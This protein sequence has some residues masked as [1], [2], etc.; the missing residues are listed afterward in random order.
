[1][2]TQAA[3][4]FFA[5]RFEEVLSLT[6]SASFGKNMAA[7]SHLCLL[8]SASRHSLWILGGESDEQLLDLATADIETCSEI[9]PPLLPSPRF[10]SPRFVDFHTASLADLAK[11]AE[12]EAATV[13]AGTVEAETGQ[14]AGAPA[15][16][17][18][19]SEASVETSSKAQG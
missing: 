5:N 9:E 19:P 4:A 3:E 13:S 8:R 14:S 7:R 15:S 12:E 1:M 18:L 10:F 6:E 16:T 17:A 2:L 11:A